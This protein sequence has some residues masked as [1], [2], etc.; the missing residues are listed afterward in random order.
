MANY[1][2]LTV[3]FKAIYTRGTAANASALQIPFKTINA[4]SRIEL[5]GTLEGQIP[6]KTLQAFQVRNE[7]NRPFQSIDITGSVSYAGEL[8]KRR[9]FFSFDIEGHTE[10]RG[11]LER[12]LPTRIIFGNAFIS[13]HGTLKKE[14]PKYA[15]SIEGSLPFV[16]GDVNIV[17][18]FLVIS[19]GGKITIKGS[20]SLSRPFLLMEGQEQIGLVTPSGLVI[21]MNLKNRAISTYDSYGIL[22]MAYLKEKMYAV[23]SDGLYQLDVGSPP[24]SVT[25]LISLPEF[26]L[27]KGEVLTRPRFI[28]M[29]FSGEGAKLIYN[30]FEYTLPETD[31]DEDMRVTIGKG[32]KDRTGKISL[33]STNDFVLRSLDLDAYVVHSKRR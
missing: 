25:R 26:D 14:K 13:I 27:K 29:S 5:V 11:R 1:A 2:D 30:Q 24:S 18:P 12:N 21:L 3:P 10:I 6:T 16:S 31:I 22:E 32:F 23:K 7:I 8:S 9:P 33:Q 15:F 28:Y 4:T 20:A 19:S 17:R